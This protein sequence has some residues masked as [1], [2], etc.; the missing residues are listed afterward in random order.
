MILADHCDHKNISY[1]TD[2]YDWHV[3]NNQQVVLVT[4]MKVIVK[5]PQYLDHSLHF[6]RHII[7]H[8]CDLRAMLL[9]DRIPNQPRLEVRKY[10]NRK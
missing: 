8:H 7:R 10:S 9:R 4:A 5:I 6:R 3:E 1:H 2:E